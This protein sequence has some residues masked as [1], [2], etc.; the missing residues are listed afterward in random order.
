MDD[1]IATCDEYGQWCQVLYRLNAILDDA[2]LN[3][4]EAS[5]ASTAVESTSPRMIRSTQLHQDCSACSQLACCYEEGNTA[6]VAV[7]RKRT[8]QHFPYN[9]RNVFSD[10]ACDNMNTEE[11][12]LNAKICDAYGPYC[13]PWYSL[14]STIS[15]PSLTR[16]TTLS[17][18]STPT[19][20][21]SGLNSSFFPTLALPSY[22]PT[23]STQP[24]L[25]SSDIASS[26]HTPFYA[27]KNISEYTAAPNVGSQPSPA[28]DSG[29]NT[30]SSYSPSQMMENGIESESMTPSFSGVISTLSPS[31]GGITQPSKIPTPSPNLN[32]LLSSLNESVAPSLDIVR[33]QMSEIPTVIM[34]SNTV[35]TTSM[36]PS[37]SLTATST[38]IPSSTPTANVSTTTSFLSSLLSENTSLAFPNKSVVPLDGTEIMDSGS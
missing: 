27:G 18:N 29:I 23:V 22:Y 1:N 2:V 7:E 6:T 37:Q 19:P 38:E 12:S 13:N 25:L 34:S 4:I 8:R 3:E 33:T 21:I 24:S 30:T 31:L 35:N 11:G 16:P 9:A 36:A 10:E 14:H 20:S 32:A 17:T 28:M 26:Q 15:I 5:C